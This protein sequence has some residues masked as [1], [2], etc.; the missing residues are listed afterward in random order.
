M[1]TA[2]SGDDLGKRGCVG[3]RASKGVRFA[4]F[5]DWRRNILVGRGMRHQRCCDF[6]ADGRPMP[7][8]RIK[9]V[10]IRV[11]DANWV[12]DFMVLEEISGGNQPG[13]ATEWGRVNPLLDSTRQKWNYAE[14]CYHIRSP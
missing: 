1:D 10:R 12:A 13:Q 8:S 6:R 5:E 11:K 9:C 4:I 2:A 14:V 3:G 7:T